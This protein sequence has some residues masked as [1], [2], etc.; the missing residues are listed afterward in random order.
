[1]LKRL[2]VENFK[3][4]RIA[5]LKLAPLTAL[6]GANSSGK[7]SLIQ[8][9]LLLKQTKDTPDRKAVFDFGSPEGF[10]NLGSFADAVYG[11]DTS[12]PIHWELEWQMPSKLSIADPGGKRSKALFEGTEIQIES[13]VSLRGK[14]PA[15]DRLSYLFDRATFVVER[16]SAERAGYQLKTK[17]KVDFSFKRTQGRVWDLPAPSKSYLFP[18]QARTYF[19]NSQF[20]GEFETAYVSQIDNVIHLGPLRAFPRREYPWSGSRPTDVGRSGENT[21]DAILAATDDD[22]TRNLGPKKRRMPFQEM[23]AWWLQTMGMIDHFHVEEVGSSSGLYRVRVRKNQKSPDVLLTD[24]GFGISQVL[25]ALVLLYYVPEHSTVILEQP[26]IHLHP[27][28]QTALADLIISVVKARNVQ[29]ILESHSEYLLNR[30]LRRVAE[31]DNSPYTPISPAD[32][33][34]YFCRNESG[35]SR[36]DNLHVNMFGGIENWP[37]EFFGDS[38]GE[39][40]AREEAA[41]KRKKPAAE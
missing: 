14:A 30:L 35:E 11:H 17:N 33:K 28:V 29:V 23:I 18:D 40:A 5:D 2:R 15:T 12:Q 13:Q 22:V 38:V 16:G 20:I 19:Q 24:V 8:F 27:A 10:V 31:G 3:S 41:I 6:Y 36:L 4:W 32:V 34:V 9:L 37:E 26:E 39:M 1:M 7:S 21:I 25:P